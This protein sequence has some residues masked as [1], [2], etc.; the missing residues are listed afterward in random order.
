MYSVED[1]FFYE[2]LHDADN[3]KAS[4]F[5]ILMLNMISLYNLL[6][7]C[8]CLVGAFG[9]IGFFSLSRPEFLW[10]IFDTS[11]S[12]A[13]VVRK[14]R[15]P[16]NPASLVNINSLVCPFPVAFFFLWLYL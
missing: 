15:V 16:G 1:R 9:F 8:L 7:F 2:L 3:S 5:R 6:F 14:S 11:A 10:I 4:S 13:D 12:V